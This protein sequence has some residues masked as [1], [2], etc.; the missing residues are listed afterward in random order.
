M[1]YLLNPLHGIY[2]Q[3]SGPNPPAIPESPHPATLSHSYNDQTIQNVRKLTLIA[4]IYR[5]NSL[6]E[7]IF[8][9][10]EVLYRSHKEVISLV[11][12][13]I[14]SPNLSEDQKALKRNSRFKTFVVEYVQEMV[15][16]EMSAIVSNPK[17][18]IYKQHLKGVT[19]MITIK[20]AVGLAKYTINCIVIAITNCYITTV[21]QVSYFITI[22]TEISFQSASAWQ[23]G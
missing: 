6:S 13:L 5:F 15:K 22:S 20:S 3:F 21:G 10:I 12:S 2:L 4:K 23:S 14:E 19:R 9:H 8:I 11:R 1:V 17:L 18:S 16:D 7:A